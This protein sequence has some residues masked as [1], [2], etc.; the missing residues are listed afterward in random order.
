MS[1]LILL[2]FFD[3]RKSAHEYAKAQRSLRVCMS[4]RGGLLIVVKSPP[5]RMDFPLKLDTSPNV[6]R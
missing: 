2:L 6:A 4:I 3:C 5:P 1:I